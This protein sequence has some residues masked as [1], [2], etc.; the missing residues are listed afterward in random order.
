MNNPEWSDIPFVPP[1]SYSTGRPNGQPRLVVVHYTAGSEGPTSAEDG[2]A[3]DQR[4]TDGTSAHYYVDRNSIVQCVATWDRAHAALWNG[5]Q[6]GIHYELCGTVQTR[7]QWLDNASLATLSRAAIQMRRDMAKYGIPAVKLSPAQVRA[8]ARGVCGHVDI[9]YAWPEDGGD[10]TDPGTEFPWDVFMR[11]LQEGDDM[12]LTDEE[13]RKLYAWVAHIVEV[14][15]AFETGDPLMW[16]QKRVSAQ[17]QLNALAQQV[18]ALLTEVRASRVA[19]EAMAAAIN[20]GGG[21]V[22]TAAILTRMTELAEADRVREEQLLARINQLEQD[23][24][25][26]DAR[27]AAALSEG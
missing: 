27:L 7:E 22:E 12:V 24:A 18:P 23:L 21:S 1:Q 14:L 8:G 13:Q 9:T 15:G 3:Y 19:V 4:R 25:D 2:A 6:V 26:R 11:L 17:D 20:A 5:N 10:H 16:T